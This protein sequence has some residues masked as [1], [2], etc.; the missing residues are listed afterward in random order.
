M[1][2]SWP[3]WQRQGIWSC[4]FSQKLLERGILPPGTVFLGSLGLLGR[5]G[6]L[7][8]FLLQPV[9][10]TGS[11]MRR[12]K[13]RATHGQRHSRDKWRTWGELGSS[14]KLCEGAGLFQADGK[15]WNRVQGWRGIFHCIKLINCSCFRS[16]LKEPRGFPGEVFLPVQVTE[17][18]LPLIIMSP[19]LLY[20]NSELVRFFLFTTY[21]FWFFPPAESKLH[22]KRHHVYF[23][24]HRNSRIWLAMQFVQNKCIEFM[25]CSKNR[26]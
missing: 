22:G 18:H 11:L 5:N 20:Q 21:Y 4:S 7:S 19:C 3:D 6:C 13:R 23:V 15:V 1:W 8:C 25:L 26:K 16:Q 2:L 12:V 17:N 10:S 14:A 9:L 24:C